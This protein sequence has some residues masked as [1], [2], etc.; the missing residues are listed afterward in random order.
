[1]KSIP[2]ERKFAVLSDITRAQHFAWREAVAELCPDVDV[3][4]VVLKMWDITGVATARSYEKR[5]DRT[6]P[7]APQVAEHIA[8]SSRC[9]GEDAT[10]LVLADGVGMVQHSACPWHRW[11]QRCGLED[12]DQ[13]GC[14]R[15]F[16]STLNAL[17][18]A[19]AVRLR[20][21]TLESLPNGDDQC[22]RRIWL[23][24]TDT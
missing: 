19:L 3:R 6:L 8:W 14:D 12:E 17:N 15:W 1:M 2:I 10:A 13:P 21:E 4:D 20:F 11:H 18:E 16:S 23:E 9:M 7:L 24:S 5:I 22:S